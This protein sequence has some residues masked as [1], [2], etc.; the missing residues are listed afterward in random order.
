M[1]Q[2]LMEVNPTG[3]GD[4]LLTRFSAGLMRGWSVEDVMNVGNYFGPTTVG[5]I[6]IP[7]FNNEHLQNLDALLVIVPD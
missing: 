1:F 4:S 3:V 2:P 7:R 5:Q 6:G